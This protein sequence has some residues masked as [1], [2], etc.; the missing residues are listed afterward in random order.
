QQDQKQVHIDCYV[1]Q[2]LV[3]QYISHWSCSINIIAIAKLMIQSET[4]L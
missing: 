1:H 3:L 2:L 4:S